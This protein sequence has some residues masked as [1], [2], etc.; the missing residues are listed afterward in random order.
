MVVPLTHDLFGFGV[1][2][3]GEGLIGEFTKEVHGAVDFKR[4]KLA[5]GSHAIRAL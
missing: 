5:V 1:V 3:S 2:Q 4:V